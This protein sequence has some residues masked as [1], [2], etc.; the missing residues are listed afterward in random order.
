MQFYL[1]GYQPGDPTVQA[2]ERPASAGLPATTDVLIVGTGPAGLVLAAQLAQ[3]ADI[4]TCVV[5]RREGPL[6]LYA[7]LGFGFWAIELHGNPQPIGICG[8]IRRETLPDVDIA[9]A[10]IV[11]V[12]LVKGRSATTT[13]TRERARA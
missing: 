4:S 13:P 7:R 8:L 10:D 11:R 2:A 12:S 1:N 9:G 3:C 5:E 6:T